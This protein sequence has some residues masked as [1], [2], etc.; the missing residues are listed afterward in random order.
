MARTS[1][2]LTAL[3]VSRFNEPG[4]FPVGENLYLQISK[5][6]SKSWLFR[7]SLKGKST[8]MGLGS[9]RF[10]SL[11]DARSKAVTIHKDLLNGIDPLKE[12]A[13]AESQRLLEQAKQ[14][15]FQECAARYIESHSPSWKNPKHISQ[16]ISTITMYANPVIG[17]LPVADI[18]TTLVLK[19]LEPIWYA[20][21]ETASRLRGRIEKILS[22]AAV[23][24]F[25]SKENPAIWR[26]HLDQLLPKRTSIQPIV[27][28]EALPFTE[29][30]EFCEKLRK[31]TDIGA[32]ALEFAIL[33][34]TRTNE[35]LKAKWQEINFEKKFWLIP[36]ERM[37]AKKEHKVP[38]SPRALEILQPMRFISNGDYIFPGRKNGK[39][40]SDMALLMICRKMN[41]NVTVHGFRSTF[42]D[43]ASETTNH[44]NDVIE[45]ALAHTINNKVEAAYRRGDLFNKR[46][47]LMND[48]S[49]YCLSPPVIMKLNHKNE[50]KVYA[51]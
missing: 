45:M 15:T 6:G 46:Q 35:T 44:S 43:W 30:P 12:K 31:N 4:K 41:Y 51:S 34:A 19:V 17:E 21:T 10:L 47:D 39:P 16:W 7:Y 48:W 14:M 28:F 8:W 37:K 13:E 3:E 33:T 29:I 50:T 26:G 11:A 5:S 23:R 42:R 38:L 40:M 24:G 36:A 22:W 20:K 2:K 27:H 1:R 32:L 18:D 9:A 49:N 25:R